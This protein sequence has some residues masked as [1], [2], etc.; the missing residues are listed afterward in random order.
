MPPHCASVA[1]AAF[2][3]PQP[4][5]T[6]PAQS[7]SAKT[8]QLTWPRAACFVPVCALLLEHVVSRGGE[9]HSHRGDRLGRSSD[10]PFVNE[11]KGTSEGYIDEKHTCGG[12]VSSLESGTTMVGAAA[13]ARVLRVCSPHGLTTQSFGLHNEE[14]QSFPDHRRRW[15][16][17]LRRGSR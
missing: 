4:W 2:R 6:A 1:L 15:R 3:E 12:I 17:Q 8:V 16:R 13:P 11:I 10:E 5:T 14:A 7:L 9:R